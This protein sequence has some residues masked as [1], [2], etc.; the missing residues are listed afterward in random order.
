MTAVLLGRALVAAV[1]TAV[2]FAL[3]AFDGP[4]QGAVV[5]EVGGLERR[6]QGRGQP[7]GLTLLTITL[8]LMLRSR[9]DASRRAA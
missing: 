3:K 5:R 9:T 7:V 1:L 8:V 4:D 6:H 2:M